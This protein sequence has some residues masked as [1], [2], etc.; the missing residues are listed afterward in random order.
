MGFI[1]TPR[2]GPAANPGARP[3]PPDNFAVSA[4]CGSL[5]MDCNLS[6]VNIVNLMAPIQ[7]PVRTDFGI[8]G[9]TVQHPKGT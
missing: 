3:G 8:G 9:H 1:G 7:Y 6:K 4:S 5:A 2:A